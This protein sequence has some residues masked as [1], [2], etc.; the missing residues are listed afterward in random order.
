[1]HA[2][3][4]LFKQLQQ[5]FEMHLLGHWTISQVIFEAPE[6]GPRILGQR[7]RPK[8]AVRGMF[9]R[10]TITIESTVEAPPL[11]RI[12]LVGDHGALITGTI[13]ETTWRE[14]AQ[15]IKQH[16]GN[17]LDVNGY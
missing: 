12:T 6:M 5:F 3:T 2:R 16:E 1:M 14:A 11:G 7:Q 9:G 17:L 15:A 4:L 13:D 8:E 10:W